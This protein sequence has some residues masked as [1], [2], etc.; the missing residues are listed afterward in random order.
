MGLGYVLAC[1]RCNC[2]FEGRTGKGMMYY[3]L[4]KLIPMI[5]YTRRKRLQEILDN[6]QVNH[7][8]F[9]HRV[10]RCTKCLRLGTRFYVNVEYDNNQTFETV[11]KCSK[12]KHH[13]ED[14]STLFNHLD[15]KEKIPFK[16]PN[17][18]DFSLGVT[19]L[20]MWD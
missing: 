12:C 9:D 18:L 19:D 6:H 14:V 17:C 10:Y 20:I 7:T 11:F 2:S 3:D 4:N 15:F 1:D 8:D 16:C 13:L 5:H